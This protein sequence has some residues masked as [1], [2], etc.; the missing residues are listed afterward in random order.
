MDL[1]EIEILWIWAR[2][3]VR[4]AATLGTERLPFPAKDQR[5]G[6]SR[7]QASYPAQ[8]QLHPKTAD[9]TGGSQGS[10]RQRLHLYDSL[11]LLGWGGGLFGQG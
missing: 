7:C 6:N 1:G 5:R 11:Q 10:S 2:F 8:N 9:R 3:N 4:S